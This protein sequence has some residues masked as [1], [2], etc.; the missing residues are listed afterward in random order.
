MTDTS[1]T[2]GEV[3]SETML[4]KTGERSLQLGEDVIGFQLL[5]LRIRDSVMLH[6]SVRNREMLR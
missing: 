2:S 3:L 4:Q 5:T 1:V 6:G